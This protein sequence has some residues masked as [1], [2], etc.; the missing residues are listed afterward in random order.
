L[1]H[2]KYMTEIKHPS[3]NAARLHSS[4]KE[5]DET[6][7]F[8][9]QLCDQRID[10]GTPGGYLNWRCRC[11][12]CTD[13]GN[14][15]ARN[16]AKAHRE[17]RQKE[18]KQAQERRTAWMHSLKIGLSCF[19]CRLE[20]TERN[21]PAFD[22]DHRIGV[23]KEFNLSERSAGRVRILAEIAKCDL[24]CSN[25]HRLKT[26]RI[27]RHLTREQKDTI[28]K[29]G[30]YGDLGMPI[31]RDCLPDGFSL[32]PP[33]AER[34]EMSENLI[35]CW[36][37]LDDRQQGNVQVFWGYGGSNISIPLQR[38]MDMVVRML[39]A[40]TLDVPL[41]AVILVTG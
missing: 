32:Q 6:G 22:W 9:C 18:L 20:C 41:D 39:V 13:A 7:H 35:P 34:L 27:D 40:Q 12:A 17:R 23:K 38:N 1:C 29:F 37:R 26:H 2:T 19:D 16:Q 3:I 15:E 5:R 30:G 36:Y 24:R 21:F 4:A 11:R 8:L 31:K 28:A 25:C 14:Q 10:H 33:H